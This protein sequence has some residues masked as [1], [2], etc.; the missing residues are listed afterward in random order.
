M[1]DTNDNT[2]PSIYYNIIITLPANATYYTFKITNLILSNTNGININNLTP[3]KLKVSETSYKYAMKNLVGSTMT[4]NNTVKNYGSDG[5]DKQHRFVE[6]M[7]TTGGYKGGGLFITNTTND[8]LYFFDNSTYRGAIA[9]TSSEI[10]FSPIYLNP[11]NNYKKASTVIW[12]G[13]VLLFNSALPQNS[14]YYALW[15]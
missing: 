3:L 13:A 10:N 5:M 9:L 12:E 7:S 11:V 14:I 15:N 1:V 6:Y 8:N 4:V 2:L